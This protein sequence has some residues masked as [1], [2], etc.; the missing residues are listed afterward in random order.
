MKKNTKLEK[1]RNSKSYKDF[2][3]RID[4]LYEYD[5]ERLYDWIIYPKREK[6]NTAF[7]SGMIRKIAEEFEY[8]LYKYNPF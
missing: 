5:L 7:P 4:E 8:Q 3:K 6:A 2:K 1:R